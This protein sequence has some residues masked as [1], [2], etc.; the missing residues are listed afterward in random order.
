MGKWERGKVEEWDDWGL[1]KTRTH[2]NCISLLP[3]P[4]LAVTVPV[5]MATGQ[6]NKGLKET[7]R[8]D[9]HCEPIANLVF[10]TQG[11]KVWTLVE[12]QHSQYLKPTLA[13][14]GRAYFYSSLDPLS[15]TS[16][17][18]V[19]RYEVKTQAGD[20]MYV[21]TW[22]WHRVEY[23]PGITAISVSLFEFNTYEFMVNNPLFAVTL[24]PN[25]VKEL[26]GFK[27]T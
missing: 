25:I 23:L 15:S 3:S 6:P 14:D 17:D 27:F 19:P 18:H 22:T 20:I 11:E 21:P 24:F 7:T 2:S 4:L 8:T 10:Q 1:N 26:L 16:L 9:L 13:P 12:P 5:F